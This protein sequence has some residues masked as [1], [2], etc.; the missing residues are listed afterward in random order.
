VVDALVAAAGD[1]D[2]AAR[3][4]AYHVADWAA[5]ISTV[6]PGAPAPPFV[7]RCALLAA[8]APDVIEC[9][10]EVAECGPVV[11]DFQS[12]A[13]THPSSRAS[14]S[15]ASLILVVADELD[16]LVFRSDRT[17]RMSPGAAL[18]FMQR[19]ADDR[20]RPVV[21]AAFRCLYD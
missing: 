17:L 8:M 4:Q 9:I 16:S 3:E 2:P 15:T 10:P 6:V 20:T 12:L 1:G 7:R 11:R 21:E 5:R 19:H 13:M 14:T 18:R